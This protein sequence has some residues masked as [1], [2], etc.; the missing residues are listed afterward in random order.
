MLNDKYISLVRYIGS[1]VS[2]TMIE[3]ARTAKSSANLRTV[4]II[5]GKDYLRLTL[6]KVNI[7]YPI[8]FNNIPLVL[9]QLPTTSTSSFFF[10]SQKTNSGV[11]FSVSGRVPSGCGGSS[12]ALSR[13]APSS[14]YLLNN[15]NTEIQRRTRRMNHPMEQP[16]HESMEGH[17]YMP[18]PGG[19]AEYGYPGAIHPAE[20]PV[21][22]FVGQVVFSYLAE[23]MSLY[24]KT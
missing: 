16:A 12:G 13:T 3:R 20:D 7:Q 10:F 21:K 18:Y 5:S 8:S 23:E 17:S 4:V 11:L 2:I 22:L 1:S 14:Y 9:F 15:F 6:H 24:D 19:E